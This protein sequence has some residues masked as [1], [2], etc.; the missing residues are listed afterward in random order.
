MMEDRLNELPKG[1][2][3]AKLGEVCLDPQYGWTTSAAIK[4]KLRLLRTTDITSGSINWDSVPFCKEEPPEKGKYILKDGDIVIS[5]AGSIG[6]SSLIKNPKE[7]IFASYLIRFRPLVDEVYFSHFLKSPFYWASIF[8]RSLGIAIPNVNASKLRQIF[9]PIPPLPEQH[10]IVAKIEE[11]FTKLDAGVEALKKIKAQLKRY[12]QAVLKYAFE[13][14]LTQAWR[15]ANKGTIEP[16]TALLERIMVKRGK[17]T[18][19]KLESQPLDTKDLPDLPKGW[20]W[21]LSR[22]L[23]WFVTSGSR[24]W[25]KYYSRSG[26]IF[27]RTQDINKNKLS[28]ENVSFVS[29]P[30]KVEGKRSLI[31][32]NDLLIIITGANVGKVALVDKE[33]D[34]AY[35][36][37]SVALMKLVEPNIANFVH[38]AMIADG[39]GKSQIEKMVYGMGRPVLSLENVQNIPIPLPP[40]AEQHK[41]VSEIESRLSIADNLEKIV[42]QS[43]KHSDTLRQSILKR[44]FEGKLVPQDPTDE[45]ADKLLERIRKEKAKREAEN[46]R[47]KKHRN[48]N[49]KQMELI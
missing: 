24:D 46:R 45:P 3:W 27:I 44:A 13:G 1:W 41:I 21:T 31:Q 14:K 11:L 9:V 7:S 2:V 8:E 36:S 35:V 16:A 47:E 18:K 10:R 15:E 30:K 29:L 48:K 26:A 23:S 43:L 5:R 42:D 19:Q 32:K 22:K 6:Y 20:V 37:Q 17:L 40:L 38:L 34:E 33:V 12:R 49:S 25:K 28:L 4:G 39:F